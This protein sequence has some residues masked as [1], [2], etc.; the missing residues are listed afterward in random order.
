MED[1][2]DGQFLHKG[3]LSAEEQVQQEVIFHR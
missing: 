1:L 3:I 2:Q